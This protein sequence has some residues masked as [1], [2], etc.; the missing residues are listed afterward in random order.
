MS[1]DDETRWSAEMEKGGMT[2]DKGYSDESDDNSTGDMGVK[3][4]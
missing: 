2:D 3:A 4:L 1:L